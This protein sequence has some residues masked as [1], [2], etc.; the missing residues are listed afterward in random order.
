MEKT[1]TTLRNVCKNSK[2]S[3]MMSKK[4]FQYIKDR[5]KFLDITK[6]EKHCGVPRGSLLNAI[7]RE[8]NSFGQSEKLIPFLDSFFEGWS[9]KQSTIK[10]TQ[11]NQ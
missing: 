1:S 3:K 5:R 6:I 4:A 9:Q 8:Q 10:N 2:R 7:N 11:W